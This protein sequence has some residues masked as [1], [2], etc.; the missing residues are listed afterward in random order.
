M[1]KDSYANDN[2]VD[3]DLRTD[4]DLMEDLD[5][6]HKL[7]TDDTQNPSLVKIENIGGL[8]SNP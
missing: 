7:M 2:K 1:V 5:Q 3:S 6:K 8:S 4:R